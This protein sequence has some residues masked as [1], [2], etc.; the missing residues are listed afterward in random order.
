MRPSEIISLVAYV[1]LIVSGL[2]RGLMPRQRRQVISFGLLGITVVFCVGVSSGYFPTTGQVIGDWIPEILILI[3]YWQSGGFYRNPHNKLQ[4]WL[5]Y[6]DQQQ[7]GPL[8]ERWENDWSRTWLGTYFELAYLFCYALVP[9][10]IAVL[11]L[12]HKR[13]WVDVYWE[14]VLLA[15]YLCYLVIPFAPTIPPRFVNQSLHPRS[16]IQSFNV[17]ILRHASI[18]DVG[19]Q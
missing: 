4:N 6:F 9:A 13:V 8:L 3:V 2:L 1:A 18:R 17:F 11:Y 19:I 14:T 10:G 5:E 12:A 7:L 16:R 15:T